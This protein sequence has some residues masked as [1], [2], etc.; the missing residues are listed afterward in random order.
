MQREERASR[1]EPPPHT[2]EPLEASG[3]LR[4]ASCL[5]VFPELICQIKKANP[6]AHQQRKQEEE[7]EVRKAREVQ[8][9]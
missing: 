8:K 7:R 3:G 1:T 6:P 9:K 4:V 2:A 5:Q